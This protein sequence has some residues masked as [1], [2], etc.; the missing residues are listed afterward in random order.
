MSQRGGASAIVQRILLAPPEV[1]YDEWL[2]VDALAEFIAPFPTRP[3]RIELDPRI[4]GLY[5]IEMIDPD[6]VVQVTGVYLELD[7][8]RRLRFTWTSDLG[9]GFDSIVTVTLKPHGGAR[10]L[11]TIE[12]TELPPEWRADHEKGWTQ[13]ARQL[14]DKLAPVAG[15]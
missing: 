7:R 13:I 14:E 1:V 12:H 15:G 3:G 5:K 6:R 11:M 4:G 8:P 9:G 10:T 2:D